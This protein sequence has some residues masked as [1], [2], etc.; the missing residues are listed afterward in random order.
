MSIHDFPAPTAEQ[1]RREDRIEDAI[2]AILD[3]GGKLAGI[4]EPVTVSERRGEP[5]DIVRPV[6]YV[7]EK[8]VTL[9]PASER[10]PHDRS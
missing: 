5:V 1:E 7:A 9:G 10:T 4:G 2:D 3:G 8:E 6:L